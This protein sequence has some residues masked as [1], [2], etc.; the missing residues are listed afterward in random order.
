MPSVLIVDD[1]VLIRSGLSALIRAT[2]DLD[3]CG[4]AESGEQAVELAAQRRPDVILMDIRLPGMDGVAATERILATAEPPQPRVLMLT[5]YDLDDH[6]YAA[7]RAG[8]SG[9]LLKDT[10]PERLFAAIRTVAAGDMLFAP[11]VTRRLIET[12]L[13]RRTPAAPTP[14]KLS[15]LTDRELDVLTLI[16]QGLSNLEIAEKLTI[17]TATVKTHVNRM[18]SKLDLRSRAQAVA[19]AYETGLIATA[20]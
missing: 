20:P 1:Q 5:S 12:Y 8:A 3:V 14:A 16:G 11:T 6:V 2:Q 9:F 7:L 13:D 17:S 19:V 15:P 10:P 18:M 4:E